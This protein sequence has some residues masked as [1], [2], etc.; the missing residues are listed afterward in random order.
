M[1]K[2]QAVLTVVLLSGAVLGFALTELVRPD[3]ELSRTERR[4]LAQAPELTWENLSSGDYG[5]DLETYL[6]D[7]FPL[8]DQLRTAMGAFRTRVLGQKDNNG[9]Y[10]QNGWLCKREDPLKPEQVQWAADKITTLCDTLLEG[11]TVRWAVVPD[12]S[13]LS[14]TEHPTL[15][16]EALREQIAASVPEGVEEIPL[17]DLLEL[18][19]Y[20]RTDTH[21][22]QERIGPVAERILEAF[23]AQGEERD[24]EAHTLS[25]FTGVYY[26][27]AA[28]PSE[29][30][31]MVYL[32]DAVTE[33]ALV[34]SAEVQGT[35]P[36]YVLDKFEGLDSYDIFLNGAQAV[37][38]IENPLAQT[39]RELILFRDSF[40]SSLAPLLLGS[41]AKV[42]LVDLRYLSSQILEQYVDFHPGQD[43]LFLYSAPLWNS[44]TLL[45]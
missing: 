18:E 39:D 2:L 5:E 37:V 17:A 33:N 32:T 12:K 42:T 25:G 15:D 45:K 20:Y 3:E 44:G 38:T 4:K 8:R 24:Y 11:S 29:P 36:M 10:D 9:Y 22:R 27:Q 35:L 6:S 30:E 13:Q 14:G 28:L 26:G 21:W 34:T 43:V 1:K 19:D 41:Y 40:G 7:Q 23:G 31:D 16:L